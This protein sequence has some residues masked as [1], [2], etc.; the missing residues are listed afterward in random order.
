MR[1]ARMYGDPRA[2]RTNGPARAP[3]AHP[4]KHA[5]VHAPTYP[6]GMSESVSTEPA[7]DSLRLCKMG[8]RGLGKGVQ[9]TI[10]ISSATLV[11]N[12]SVVIAFHGQPCPPAHCNILY[13]IS[14]VPV[15]VSPGPSL[16]AARFLGSYNEPNPP[17]PSPS[18]SPSPR[19]GSSPGLWARSSGSRPPRT[20]PAARTCRAR[21]PAPEQSR[22]LCG[23]CVMDRPP[24]PL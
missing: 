13:R 15:R 21:A 19:T 1:Y 17:F 2:T 10:R 9:L 6:L 14:C 12:Q 5:S 3:K 4:R 22:A 16:F 20:D 11:N 23:G 8:R 18:P 24:L 7:L